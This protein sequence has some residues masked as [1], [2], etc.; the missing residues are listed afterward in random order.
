[1]QQARSLSWAEELGSIPSSDADL[2]HDLHDA[3]LHHASSASE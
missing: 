3:D 2:L 1:M